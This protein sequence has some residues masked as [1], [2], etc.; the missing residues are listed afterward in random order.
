MLNAPVLKIEKLF[1]SEPTLKPPLK[2]EVALV[3]LEKNTPWVQMEVVVAA[4]VVLQVEATVNGYA[5]PEPVESV[6]QKRMPPV[7]DFT[8]QLALVRFVIASDVVVAFVAAR[9][10]EKI[11]VEVEFVRSADVAPSDVV[12]P[13]VNEKLI[14][15]TRPA[16]EIE[17]SVV[18]ADPVELAIKNA[19]L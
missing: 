18:V 9:Y 14:P 10:L 1:V 7:V 16:L 15:V 2:V 3:E 4:V 17:K 12:V 11:F 13:L 8:S 5:N 6:P 19:L